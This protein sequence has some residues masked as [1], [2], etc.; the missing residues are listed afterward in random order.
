VGRSRAVLLK[1]KGS[2]GVDGSPAWLVAI[3]AAGLV[4][5]GLAL[6][7]QLRARGME[8]VEQRRLGWRFWYGGP[9]MPTGLVTA[10]K[11]A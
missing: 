2:Y 11:P 8:G 9:W 5:A 4:L 3:G 7:K 10:A 1:P 6:A